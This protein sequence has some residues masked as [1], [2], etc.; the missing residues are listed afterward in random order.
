MSGKQCFILVYFLLSDFYSGKQRKRHLPLQCRTCLVPPEPI[1]PYKKNINEDF[2]TF[3][4]FSKYTSDKHTCFMF[5]VL[6]LRRVNV[7][8]TKIR[9]VTWTETLVTNK[10]KCL[11]WQ[12]PVRCSVWWSCAPFSPTVHSWLWVSRQTGQRMW[13]K[14]PF[15]LDNRWFESQINN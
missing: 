4:S 7:F 8:I 9:W 13:S 2:S 5:T 12:R 15:R 11:P 10:D 14:F 3:I 1:Q 6:Y